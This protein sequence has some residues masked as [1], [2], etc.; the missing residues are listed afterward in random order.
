MTGLGIYLGLCAETFLLAGICACV[1]F[2][3]GI[4]DIRLNEIR[5]RLDKISERADE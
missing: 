3:F 4:T 5:E 2:L 1:L